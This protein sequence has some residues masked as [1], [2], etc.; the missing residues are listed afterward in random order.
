MDFAKLTPEG[1]T[2]YALMTP[3]QNDAANKILE[4]LRG[5]TVSEA[6]LTLDYVREA[7]KL[8]IL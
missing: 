1:Q 8:A 3:G 4:T 5:F 6:A 7:V 2:W